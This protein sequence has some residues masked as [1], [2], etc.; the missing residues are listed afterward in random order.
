M[1]ISN[2]PSLPQLPIYPL[3]RSGVPFEFRNWKSV[4][5]ETFGCQG[6]GFSDAHD[7]DHGRPRPE[8]SLFSAFDKKKPSGPP[9]ASGCM[10]RACLQRRRAQSLSLR[11]TSLGY[12]Q[13]KH[14]KI[15]GWRHMGI[16]CEFLFFAYVLP[17]L[18]ICL[19]VF[20]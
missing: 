6:Q 4:I 16:R 2:P 18:P 7:K 12:L 19:C 1:C 13:K 8:V 15:E 20:S 17:I 9:C 14:P 11:W 3:L 10:S 5:T